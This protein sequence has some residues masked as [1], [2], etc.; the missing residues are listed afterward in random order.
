MKER[1]KERKMERRKERRKEGC[2]VGNVMFSQRDF[3]SFLIVYIKGRSRGGA[4]GRRGGGGGAFDRYS[5]L[6]LNHYIVITNL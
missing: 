5:R 6:H 1:R 2:K 3:Q 4:E